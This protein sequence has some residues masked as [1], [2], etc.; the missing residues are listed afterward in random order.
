MRPRLPLPSKSKPAIVPWYERNGRA[1]LRQDQAAIAEHYPGLTFQFDEEKLQYKLVGEIIHKSECGIPTP[2][3]TELWFPAHYPIV[4]PW[5]YEVG[6]RF[7]RIADRHFY[8]EGR[9]CLWLREESRWDRLAS[10]GLKR[11]L[12]EVAVFF[13]R[14]LVYDALPLA[15]RK[16]PGPERSHGTMG[17]WE[18]SRDLIDSDDVILKKLVPL[19]VVTTGII[20]NKK[21]PC[22]SNKKLKACHLNR[23]QYLANKLDQKVRFEIISFSNSGKV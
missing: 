16:W 17:Y 7:E 1:R 20:R 4:E 21:C 6:N 14:Q 5:V 12:D 15:I 3:C 23:I 2:I 11:F 10:D 22:G 13:D 8:P 19:L 9:C 18:L